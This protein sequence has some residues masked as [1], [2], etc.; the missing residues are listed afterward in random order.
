MK[1]DTR[2]ALSACAAVGSPFDPVNLHT[3]KF[4]LQFNDEAHDVQTIINGYE[5]GGDTFVVAFDVHEGSFLHLGYDPEELVELA[6]GFTGNP[7]LV[8]EGQRIAPSFTE[9]MAEFLMTRVRDGNTR[10]K[11]VIYTGFGLG[12]ALAQLMAVLMVPHALIT[13]GTPA[14][15]N[16]QYRSLFIDRVAGLMQ[17][18][19]DRGDTREFSFLNYQMVDDMLTQRADEPLVHLG[20]VVWWNQ[21]YGW[22]ASPFGVVRRVFE[23]FTKTRFTLLDDYRERLLSK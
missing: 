20:Q 18:Y 21:L 17:K 7:D 13:F 9:H 15:V 11:R 14:F 4:Q 8:S 1:K 6:G 19:E 5:M 22:D 16:E 3:L 2:Y 10:Y 12:G 23:F